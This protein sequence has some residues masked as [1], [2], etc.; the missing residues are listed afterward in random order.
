MI[1]RSI[2]FLF[3][4]LLILAAVAGCTAPAANPQPSAAAATAAPADQGAQ[5]GGEKKGETL[6]IGVVCPLSGSGAIAGK[7][8]TNGIKLIENK[9]TAEGGLL[10]GDTRY[11]IQFLY[12]DNEQKKISPRTFIR[13]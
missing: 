10:V 9:L 12:E 4:A 5:T 8:I 1:R 11:P 2:S 13:S 3:A 6:K 7:Y